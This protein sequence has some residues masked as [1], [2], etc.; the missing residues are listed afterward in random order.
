M[1]AGSAPHDVITDFNANDV[2][3]LAGYGSGEAAN[4][5]ATGVSSGGST[6]ITLSD[7]T[8]ITFLDISSVNALAHVVSF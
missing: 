3:Y 4:V 8:Q 5:L 2:L 1:I 7:N 6:T